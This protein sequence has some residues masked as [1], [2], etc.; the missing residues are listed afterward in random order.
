VDDVLAK[1]LVVLGSCV[2]MVL[3]LVWYV[4]DPDDG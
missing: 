1:V 2:M 4:S 3:A